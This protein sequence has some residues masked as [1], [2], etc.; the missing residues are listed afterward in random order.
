SDLRQLDQLRAL[1]KALLPANK[2]YSKKFKAAEVPDSIGSLPQFSSSVPFTTKAEIADDQRAF[3]PFGN[4]LSYP[5]ERYVR[6]HQTSGTSGAPLRWLDTPESWQSML[7]N[8]EQILRVAGV[9]A[10]DPVFFAF[11]FGPLDRK[12]VV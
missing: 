7:G 8:W 2:F 4:N 9:R 3:P 12:S 6:Y 1:W 5:L 10:G 11:S